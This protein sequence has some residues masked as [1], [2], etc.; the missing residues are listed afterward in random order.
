M[1]EGHTEPIKALGFLEDGKT[2]ASGSSDCTLRLWNTETQDQQLIPVKHRWFAFDFAFSEDGK[3]VAIGST[4]SNVTVECRYR[5]LYRHLQNGTQGLYQSSYI[6]PK[7]QNSCQWESWWNS[8]IVG[9]AEPS[10]YC[11][12]TRPYGRN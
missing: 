8:R 1:M 7:R 12:T 2:L 9:C 10:A 11:Y 6:L 3:T 5:R 4:G